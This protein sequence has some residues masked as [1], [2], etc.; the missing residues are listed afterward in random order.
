MM[1][2]MM[3]KPSL[4]QICQQGVTIVTSGLKGMDVSF[5]DD[6]LTPRYVS[7]GLLL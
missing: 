1:M 7:S 4:K 6:D 3:M 5:R 2:M